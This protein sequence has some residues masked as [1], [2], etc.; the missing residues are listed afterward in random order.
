MATPDCSSS[1][2]STNAMPGFASIIRTSLNPGYWAK[3]NCNIVLV[4]S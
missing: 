4:V 3:S 2:Y 1:S